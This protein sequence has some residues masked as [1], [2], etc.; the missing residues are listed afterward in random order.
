MQFFGPT[1]AAIRATT[2][3]EIVASGA[4]ETLKAVIMSH[5]WPAFCYCASAG[6]FFPFF[7][8]K[9]IIHLDHR[10]GVVLDPS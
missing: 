2:S 6:L 5:A 9:G 7:V 10:H 4:A 1:N 3:L 8:A